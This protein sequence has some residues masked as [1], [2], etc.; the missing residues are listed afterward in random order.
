MAD[1]SDGSWCPDTALESP[2]KWRLRVAKFGDGYEQRSLAGINALGREWKVTWSIRPRG[3]LEDMDA[4]LTATGAHS[5][6]WLEPGFGEQVTVFCDEWSI[7]W[8]QSRPDAPWDKAAYG[9]LSATFREANGV[10]A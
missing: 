8:Q 7:N 3:M 1:F 6:V 10:T 5:F 2:R 9:A 4:Y